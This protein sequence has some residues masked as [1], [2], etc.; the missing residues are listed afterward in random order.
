[1]RFGKEDFSSLTVFN[2]ECK[3]TMTIRTT[4]STIQFQ[5]PFNLEG[6]KK[7]LPSGRY[8]VETDEARIEGLSFTAL[9]RTQVRLHLHRNSKHPGTIETLVLENPK[10]LD[11]ALAKDKAISRGFAMKRI[12]IHLSQ[13]HFTNFDLQALDRADN[14]GM[15]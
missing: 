6:Y 9:R 15:H 11:T 1:M 10:D 13:A 14:E 5:N 12:G 4:S 3:A 8:Q 7:T 2:D